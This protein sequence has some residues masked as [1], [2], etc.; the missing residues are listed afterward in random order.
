MQRVIRRPLATLSLI[1]LSLVLA[2]LLAA[3][4]A[5]QTWPPDFVTQEI[6]GGW[7]QPTCIAFAAGDTLLV[8]EDTLA[9]AR[10]DGFGF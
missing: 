2:A 5:A 3:S 4:A 1:P 8:R 7:N 9:V 10:P 6:G